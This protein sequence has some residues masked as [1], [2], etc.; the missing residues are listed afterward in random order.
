MFIT[1]ETKLKHL[2][3]LYGSILVDLSQFE[4]SVNIDEGESVIQTHDREGMLS[5]LQRFDMIETAGG[6]TCDPCQKNVHLL[7]KVFEYNLL[8]YNDNRPVWEHDNMLH[9]IYS[10]QGRSGFEPSDEQLRLADELPHEWVNR[11]TGIESFKGS[12]SQDGKFYIDIVYQVDG[13][14]SDEHYE[15]SR[16]IFDQLVAYLYDGLGHGTLQ[17]ELNGTIQYDTYKNHLTI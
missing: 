4:Y 16:A 14:Y 7:S 8:K 2:E 10:D 12:E 13:E 11:M 3:K 1:R 5:A 17:Y 15:G 6:L 9:Y